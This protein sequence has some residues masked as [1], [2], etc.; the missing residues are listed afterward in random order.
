MAKLIRDV[1]QSECSWLARDYTKGEELFQY[2][3][4]TYGCI[5]PDGVAVTE[6]PDQTP[7]FE[8]PLD[9][10]DYRSNPNHE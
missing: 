7:F 6:Q 3:G 5:T 2:Y 9:A 10:F 4:A 8:M 1:L